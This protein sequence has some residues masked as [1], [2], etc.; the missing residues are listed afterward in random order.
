MSGE[1][2]QITLT[3]LGA[4]SAQLKATV[5]APVTATSPA[6][7]PPPL[8]LVPRAAEMGRDAKIASDKIGDFKIAQP[9]NERNI[10]ARASDLKNVPLPVAAVGAAP[11]A[12]VAPAK[13]QW[14]YA[15]DGEQIGPKA[16][17]A[18]QSLIMGG[19]ITRDTLLWREGLPGW[20]AASESEFAASF[21]A[22][23]PVNSI[24]PV[25]V[26]PPT[27]FGEVE[28]RD[29]Q[30]DFSREKDRAATTQGIATIGVTVLLIAGILGGAAWRSS[31]LAMDRS[32]DFE[33]VVRQSEPEAEDVKL[34]K[35]EDGRY[36]GGFVYAAG[37]RGQATVTV[38]NWNWL[39]QPTGSRVV[40]D[41]TD[42]SRYLANYV[43]EVT[44]YKVE[45]SLSRADLT[46][47]VGKKQYFRTETVMRNGREVEISVPSKLNSIKVTIRS[48]DKDGIPKDIF[49][50]E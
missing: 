48:F 28:H 34:K 41:H 47:Y 37:D 15:N 30:L 1:A 38:D 2:R 10:G 21:P 42:F 25:P 7:K 8:P 49:I 43:D 18:L 39:G 14:F 11:A 40:T 3:N 32:A 12:P 36:M 35:Q 45:V 20:I 31:N 16:R 22:G 23:A 46:T 17:V 9:Q 13:Q 24:N 33:R 27:G 4:T 6:I 29:L 19:T 44:I 50:G 5:T 26:S